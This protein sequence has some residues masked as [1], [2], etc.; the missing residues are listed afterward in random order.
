MRNGRIESRGRPL[1]SF[2][3]RG[4]HYAPGTIRPIAAP[5]LSRGAP[6]Q[7]CGCVAGHFIDASTSPSSLFTT[8][9]S[10]STGRPACRGADYH[11]V[12]D[13]GRALNPRAI[14]GQFRAA[15]YR[16]WA[17]PCTRRSRSAR[18]AACAR[19]ASRPT[20]CHWALDVVPVEISLYEGHRR[21]TARTKGAGEVPILNVGATSR[22]PWRTQ[23]ESASRNYR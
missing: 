18:T 21:W 13:V 11:V 10:P 16:A 19:I 7:P 23:Q 1:R 17:T 6:Y 15:S 12:Q 9:R 2:D 20:A 8:V 5:A 4:R 22:A 3:C 14:R